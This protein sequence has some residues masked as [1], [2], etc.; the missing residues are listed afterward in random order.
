MSRHQRVHTDEAPEALG[1]YSQATRLDLGDRSLLFL[2]GQI[3]LDPDNG[4]LVE[5]PI[6]TQVERVMQNLGAVLAAAGSGFD[7]VVK[8][9]I[10]LADMDDFAAVNEVYGRYFDEAPPAR[11]TVQAGGLPKGVGVEIEAIAYA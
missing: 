2:A 9:T 6:E 8:T 1:P 4:Q 11:A 3:P 10:F 5:G 7:R